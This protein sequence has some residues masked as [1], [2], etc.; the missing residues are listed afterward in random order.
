MKLGRSGVSDVTTN[1]FHAHSPNKAVLHLIRFVHFNP[2]MPQN[3]NVFAPKDTPSRA[4]VF[5]GTGWKEFDKGKAAMMMAQGLADELVARIEDNTVKVDISKA[6]DYNKYCKRQLE[7]DL[8]LVAK[9][10]DII[11]DYSYLLDARYNT[12]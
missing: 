3:M 1:E 6:D 12:N 2:H 9:A 5:D 11:D 10:V 4:K 8:D 7:F